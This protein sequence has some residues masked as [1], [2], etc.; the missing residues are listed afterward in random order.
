LA[1]DRVVEG[2][3]GEL[4]I[5]H[6]P[7]ASHR[8]VGCGVERLLHQ[9][10]NHVEV[11]PP[12]LNTGA[13]LVFGHKDVIEDVTDHLGLDPDPPIFEVIHQLF[14]EFASPY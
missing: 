8:D 9:P 4:T 5:D 12:H 6:D 2:P 1:V 10:P 3:F 7:L 11:E 14:Y 13:P